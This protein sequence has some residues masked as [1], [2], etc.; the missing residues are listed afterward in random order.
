[1]HSDLLLAQM[2]SGCNFPHSAVTIYGGHC[3]YFGIDM[4]G[5]RHTVLHMGP[6]TDISIAAGT[7]MG[8]GGFLEGMFPIEL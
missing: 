6:V 4:Q 7:S 2:V 5:F 8:V 3:Q 1:V